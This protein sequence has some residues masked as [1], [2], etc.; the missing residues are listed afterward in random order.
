MALQEVL[1]AVAGRVGRLGVETVFGEPRTLDGRTIIPV[2]KVGY[3]FGGGVGEAPAEGEAPKSAQGGGGGGGG[4]AVPVA[5]VEITAGETR[6]LPVLDYTRIR[7]AGFFCLG[8][9]LWVLGRAL[10]HRRR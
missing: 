7:L 9:A 8:M 2:A 5:V 4:A 3:G 10:G 6:I 1:E